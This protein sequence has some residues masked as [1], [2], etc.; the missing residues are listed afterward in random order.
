[1]SNADQL[2]LDIIMLPYSAVSIKK[3]NLL[4]IS[5]KEAFLKTF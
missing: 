1:M 2:K 3:M 4:Q 5:I